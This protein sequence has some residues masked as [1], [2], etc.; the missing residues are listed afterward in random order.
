[1]ATKV[2]VTV[3]VAE[4][5]DDDHPLILARFPGG[6]PP[7][8]E[9]DV[10]LLGRTAAGPKQKSHRRVV[11]AV[12]DKCSFVGDNFSAAAAGASAPPCSYA[13]GVFDRDTNTLTLHA[14]RS[15]VTL[16]PRVRRAGRVAD[17][18]LVG[19]SNRSKR[20]LLVNSFGSRKRRRDQKAQEASQINKDNITGGEAVRELLARSATEQGVDAQQGTSQERAIAANRRAFLP[21]FDPAATEQADVYK[22]RD[23]LLDTRALEGRTRHFLELLTD[24]PKFNEAKAEQRK[25]HLNS[26][27]VLAATN[28]YA[29]GNALSAAERKTKAQLMALFSYLARFHRLPHSLS[30]ES[31]AS[32]A[33]K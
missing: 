3:R 30:G 6:V 26:F 21:P 15:A 18:S 8:D 12:T 19:M 16:V 5:A 2:K 17:D 7:L 23:L 14:V 28:V 29:N 10:Q 24:E 13:V 22:A 33:K 32:I 25:N 31:L 4:P 1:M 11:A 9:T 27:L 20:Q